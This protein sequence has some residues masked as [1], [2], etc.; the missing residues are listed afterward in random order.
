MDQ[1]IPSSSPLHFQ[2][3]RESH[4]LSSECDLQYD[5]NGLSRDVIREQVYKP[6]IEE[7][8]ELITTQIRQ[9]E[10]GYQKT[11]KVRLSTNM[12]LFVGLTV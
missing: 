10:E 2:F 6:V 4:K 8:K 12:N 11:P 9:V 7:I 3:R 1:S 5:A